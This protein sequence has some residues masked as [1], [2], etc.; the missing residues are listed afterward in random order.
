MFK[1]I[2]T[3]KA[4]L[5]G[6]HHLCFVEPDFRLFNIWNEIG[7]KI[8]TIFGKS[9]QIG[10]MNWILKDALTLLNRG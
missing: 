7:G 5:I 2:I 9:N 10:Q 4:S 6:T 3:G 1:C 8:K